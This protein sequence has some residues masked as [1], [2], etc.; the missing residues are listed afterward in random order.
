MPGQSRPIAVT[1][2]SA[3]QDPESLPETSAL[4]LPGQHDAQQ[5]IVTC[6]MCG[7]RMAAALMVADGGTACPDVRWYP[8]RRTGGH[9]AGSRLPASH[10]SIRQA[11]LSAVHSGCAPGRRRQFSPAVQG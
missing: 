11:P 1:T 7:I 4:L 3:Q 5:T 2:E 10:G 6:W 9:G 8:G